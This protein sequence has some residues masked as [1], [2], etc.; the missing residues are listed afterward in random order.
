M[1]NGSGKEVS[2]GELMGQG[3]IGESV[4]RR[5][6][7]MDDVDRMDGDSFETVCSLIWGKRGFQAS[8]TPKKG[9]DGGIDVIAFNGREGELVQCKSSKSAE[10]GWD[11]IK[12]VVAGAARY[13]ARFRGTRFRRVAV[14]NQDFTRGAREQADANQ[15][16]LITRRRLEELLAEHPITNHEFDEAL[17]CDISLA[18]HREH[19]DQPPEAVRPNDKLTP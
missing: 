1:L 4:P 16:E 19:E 14:T 10:L 18:A 7:T 5:S 11:A 13:Q 8:V 17:L 6:L 15:V 2:I 9:G 12:E 3:G